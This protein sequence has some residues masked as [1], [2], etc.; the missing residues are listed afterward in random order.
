MK[1]SGI[2]TAIEKATSETLLRSDPTYTASVITLLNSR[3]DIPK[4]AIIHL[5]KRI[6]SRNP[7][8][9]LLTLELLE[10][11]V[12]G[13]SLPFHTQVSSKDFLQ[14][15]SQ[16]YRNKDADTQVKTRLKQLLTDW[17][18]RFADASDILPGFQEICTQLRLAGDPQTQSLPRS[19]IRPS[20]FQVERRTE[21]N[22]RGRALP[23]A[24]ADKLR[25]DLQVVVE[26]CSLFNEIID[27][28]ERWDNE[29]LVDLSETL[30]AME[31]KLVKLVQKLEDPEIMEYC[32][33]IKDQVHEAL[34]RHG[35]LKQG[36][37]V[38]RDKKPESSVDLLTGLHEGEGE[39]E[40]VGVRPQAPL[41]DLIFE[42]APARVETTSGYVNPFFSGM[43]AQP[44]PGLGANS[45]LAQ[46]N[47]G[48]GG[49]SYSQP[50]PIQQGYN[51]PQQPLDPFSSL[52]IPQSNP[53]G[54]G[55]SANTGMNPGIP[56]NTGGYMQ[57]YTNL[58]PTSQ[59][60][61]NSFNAE[62]KPQ[63]FVYTEPV[64]VF[65][66][67]SPAMRN[68]GKGRGEEKKENFDELFDFKF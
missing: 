41:H 25:S 20:A 58:P 55:N 14:T 3:P 1:L 59:F 6:I 63:K 28:G 47:F 9:Q 54:Y 11:S 24:K 34:Q 18:R 17:Q 46:Q 12:R 23:Q 65:T 26:N 49:L 22:N 56:Q 7:K 8:I 44:P 38:R 15:L 30:S 48:P 21:D 53:I 4:E 36:R 52:I 35:D 68:D 43:F 42:S 5:K 57:G 67:I 66:N 61:P 16:I 13:T 64:G 60:P 45:G 19:E 10:E 29:T 31:T 50:T 39:G 37:S 62:V 40:G 2:Q 27:A 51:P 33:Q 32:L